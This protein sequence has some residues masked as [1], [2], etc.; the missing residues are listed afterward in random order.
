M[1]CRVMSPT[2]GAKSTAW[3]LKPLR[4]RLLPQPLLLQRPLP[5]RLR[6]Q[7]LLLRRE[8]LTTLCRARFH[9]SDVK[10]DVWNKKLVILR[11]LP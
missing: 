3:I 10:S 8:P 1:T 6:L 7:L 2:S 5:Q 9:T 4:P 11:L